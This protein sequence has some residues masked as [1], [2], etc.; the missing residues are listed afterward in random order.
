[1]K[2]L[3]KLDSGLSVYIFDD[4]EFISQNSTSTTVGSPVK[5]YILDCGLDNS[6]IIENVTTPSDWKGSKYFFD[7]VTWTLNLEYVVAS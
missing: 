7:G 5:F 3:T 2:T 6:K 1:M 4:A